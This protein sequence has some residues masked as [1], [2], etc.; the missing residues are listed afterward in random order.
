MSKVLVTESHLNN[1]AEAIRAKNGASTTYRPG[2][3]AAA[4]QAIPTGGITPT[5]T[6]NIA[7]NGTHDVTQYASANVQVSNTYEATDEGKVVSNGALVA[8][9]S[10]NI[11]ENGTY[12]TTENDEVIVSVSGGGGGSSD[13]IVNMDFTKASG[14]MSNVTFNSSGA[15]FPA[16]GNAF[17]RIPLAHNDSTLYVDVASLKLS[18]GTHRRFIMGTYDSGFIYR[19]SGVWAMYSNG[20]ENSQITDPNYFDDCI[21]KLYVD[22]NNKWHIYKNNVLVW[23]PSLSLSWQ[24]IQMPTTSNYRAFAQIGSMN[25]SMIPNAII[26]GIRIYEGNYT[27]VLS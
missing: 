17:I 7:Q 15:T 23:E 14:T 22:S 20:W 8:Q 12:D 13:A 5:G 25:G 24:D 27:E 19:D 21:V 3:M 10:R 1:I 6:V 26:R 2:D 9:T 11:T 4:I 16:S 18:S